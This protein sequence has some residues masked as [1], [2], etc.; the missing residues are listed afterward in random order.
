MVYV[1][2]LTVAKAVVAVS[3]MSA[4]AAVALRVTWASAAAARLV[5]PSPKANG[6]KKFFLILIVYYYFV[7]L[8]F[9][10]AGNTDIR[11]YFWFQDSGFYFVNHLPMTC[12]IRT[13]T[14]YVSMN[15]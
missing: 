5:A 1:T 2:V 8:S 15:L 3:R 10:S 9:Q 6:A 12:F 11:A 14:T 13:D 7:L 4:R